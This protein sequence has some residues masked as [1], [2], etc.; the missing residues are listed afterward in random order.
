MAENQYDSTIS[1][2]KSSSTTFL[3]RER[4]ESLNHSDDIDNIAELETSDGTNPLSDTFE[5][6]Q[7]EQQPLYQRKLR[8]ARLSKRAVP[9]TWVDADDT[10]DF[11][12]QEEGR[13]ARARRKMAKFSQRKKF[14]WN[15]GENDN[16]F[17]PAKRTRPIQCITFRASASKAAFAEICAKSEEKADQACTLSLSGYRLRKRCGTGDGMIAGLLDATG[18]RVIASEPSWD[19]RNQPAARGCTSCPAR[20]QRCSLLDNEHCWPCDDCNESGDDCQLNQVSDCVWFLRRSVWSNNADRNLNSNRRALIASILARK[21]NGWC[22][23]SIT[24]MSL[25]SIAAVVRSAKRMAIRTVLRALGQ[26]SHARDYASVLTVRRIRT[27]PA[28]VK[29]NPG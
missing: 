26:V 5:Q 29:V 3:S 25:P 10:G 23:L 24:P 14:D 27:M 18:V 28:S 9:N 4:S 15:L 22:A 13:Q 11:D 19:P 8:P 12:P 6:Q 2:D 7:S 17:K 1:P 16:S 21:I 20:G